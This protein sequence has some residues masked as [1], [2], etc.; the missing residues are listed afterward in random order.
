MISKSLL[1]NHEWDAKN[2]TPKIVSL[3]VINIFNENK[4][5]SQ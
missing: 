4:S 1:N 3:N 5:I 2:C